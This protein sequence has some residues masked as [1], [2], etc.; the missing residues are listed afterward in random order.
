MNDPLRKLNQAFQDC[1]KFIGDNDLTEIS[2]VDK[3]IALVFVNT[4]VFNINNGIGLLVEDPLI[5]NDVDV[6]LATDDKNMRIYV[7][8]YNEST[9]KS[10][11]H[12]F[13]K[14]FNKVSDIICT[15]PMLE[16]AIS[17]LYL[18]IYLDKPGLSVQQLIELEEFFNAK[19]T[20]ELHNRPYALFILDGV[21]N[22]GSNNGEN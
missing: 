12:T 2:V 3:E 17:P 5:K 18:K 9:S 4:N 22:D 14:V 10:A 13:I 1:K 6:Y 11:F 20:L 19:C 16:Y 7:T 8:G 15:C 21:L